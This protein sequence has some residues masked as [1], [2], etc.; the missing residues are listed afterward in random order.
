MAKIVDPWDHHD[1]SSRSYVLNWAKRQDLRE[2][3]REEIFTL[4]AQTL[5]YAREAAIKILDIGAGYGALTRFLLDIFPSATALCH[6]G[7]AAMA[8]LGRRRMKRFKGRF[9]YVLCDLSEPGWSRAIAGPFEAVVSSIAIHNVRAPEIIQQ[10]YGEI[11][12]LVKAGGCFL[13]FDRMTPSLQDQT[14][15]LEEAGFVK[16][17]C[18]RDAGKRSLIGGFKQ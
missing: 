11:F 16:V 2:A 9:D 12:T 15:W 18:Y 13:N 5:P 4:M 14:R 3:D 6:D 8:K 1:W 10:I 7:S 17:K